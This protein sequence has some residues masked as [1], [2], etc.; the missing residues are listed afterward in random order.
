MANRPAPALVLREGDRGGAGAADQ[1]LQCS[2]RSGAAGADRAAGRAGAGE[3]SDRRTGR[4][5][6]SDG[7][8]VAGPLPGQGDRRSGRRGPVRAAA[9]DR[10]KEGGRGDVEAAAEEVRSDPLV[11]SAAGRAPGGFGQRG[12]ADLA[13]A[14]HPAVADGV[15]PVLHRPRSG[16]QGRRRRRPLPGSTRRRDRALRG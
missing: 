11:H 8:R 16:V 4:G 5:V 3:H 12:R 14:R 15:V 6:T 10:P 1:V 2:G 13:R 7:D 9:H